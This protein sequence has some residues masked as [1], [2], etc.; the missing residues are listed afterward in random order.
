MKILDQIN[1]QMNFELESGYIYL[2][3]ASYF[4]DRGYDGMSHFMHLQA[5]EE[6]EH[7]MK[8]YKF[9]LEVGYRPLF[10]EIAKPEAEFKDELDVFE[11]ALAHEKVV[12][13]RINKLVDLAREEND[14]RAESMLQWFIDEQVEEEDNFTG[15]V[16]KFERAGGNF[17]ALYLLDGGLGRR[18]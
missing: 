6:Y 12:T 7:A 3:M 17:G 1:E 9:L 15:I 14:K 8:M 10:K 13:S 18:E 16:E 5:H 4:A 2:S 11:K